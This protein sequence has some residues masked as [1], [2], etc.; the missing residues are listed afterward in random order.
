[1]WKLRVQLTQ[2]ISEETQ[3]EGEEELVLKE[4]DDLGGCPRKQHR[5]GH[6]S[7]SGLWTWG[8]EVRAQSGLKAELCKI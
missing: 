3:G 5:N 7:S 4:Q 1:M 8:L 6:K 2:K